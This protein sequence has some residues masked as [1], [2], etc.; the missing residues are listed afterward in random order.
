MQSVGWTLAQV[1][2]RRLERQHL[3][4]P[5]VDDIPSVVAAMCG[6]HAQVM[7]AAE[8]SIGLRMLGVSRSQVRQALWTDRTLIKTY[9]PRGTVHLLPAADL[10]MWTGALSAVPPGNPTP[11]DFGLTPRQT[12]EVV[13]AIGAALADTEPLT[14]EELGSAVVAS[15]GSWAADEVVPAFGGF[16][17]R[18]KVALAVAGQRGSLCFG[19]NRGRTVTYTSPQSWLSDA[20]PMDPAAAQLGL[21]SRYLTSFGPASP[22]HFAQWLAAPKQWAI[23]LFDAFPEELTE[24][25]VAGSAGWLMTGDTDPPNTRPA[26]V[27]LLPYFDP[28]VI[29]SHPRAEIY[30]GRATERA[31]SR[32][33]A[34]TV[35]V[36]LVNGVVGGVWHQRRAGRTVRITVE[37]LGDLNKRQR[38]QLT[39]QVERTAEILEAKP[40]LTFGPVPVGRHL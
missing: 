28:Y 9:G 1:R 10:P 26:G 12:D 6:A 29:G 5:A 18:W 17:P 35:P 25:D 27:R 32:G 40:S 38:N 2:A 20:R 36:V 3:R 39:E 34:G 8:L 30:P 7:S 15:T 16:W 4:V 19:P 21:I 14:V 31:L 33:Q 37:L 11:P 22:A 23:Q 13:A 24:V